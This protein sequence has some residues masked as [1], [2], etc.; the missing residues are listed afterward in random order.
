M[1]GAVRVRVWLVVAA[2]LFVNRAFSQGAQ[3]INMPKSSFVELITSSFL[4]YYTTGG[5]QEKLYM[6]T[7]KPYYSAG[8]TIY[9]SAFLVNAL[10][11][12]QTTET[13]FIYVE[14]IDATGSVVSRLK[15][16]GEGGRFNNALEIPTKQTP[17]RYTL[18]AYS[19]WQTNFGAEL[20]FS[21]R[22]NIGNYID[23]TVRTKIDYHFDGSGR[24]VASVEV[25]NNIYQPVPN[26]N[27]E[28]SLRV[29]GRTTQHLTKTDKEGIF[30]FSFRP[31]ANATDCVRLN[32]S[33]NGRKLDRTIQLPTFNDNFS[34]RFMPEGGNLVADIE[35]RVAFKAV[36]VDGYSV[37]IKGEVR[38]DDGVLVCRFESSHNGMGYFTIK[39]EKGRTYSATATMQGDVTKEFKLPVPIESGCVINLVNDG[40]KS[41]VRVAVTPDLSVGRFVAVVQSRGM[42]DYVVE[43]LR[44]PFAIPMEG[45]R[46]GVAMISIV[47]RVSMK[48]VAERLFF[49]DGKYATATINPSV[50]RFAPR[51][52]VSIDFHILNSKRQAVK[53]D[54]VVRVTDDE[55]IH[56]DKNQDNIFSYMLL[57]SDLK[58]HIENPCYYFEKRDNQRTAQLDLVMMTHGWRRYKVENIIA[59]KRPAI[60][61]LFEKE[62]SITGL[63]RGVIGNAKRP[64]VMIFRNRKE[65]LGVHPLNKSNKFE[66]TGVDSPDTTTYLL[67]A[68]NRQGS[69]SRVRIKVDPQVYPLSPT[70]AREVFQKRTFSSVPEEFLMSSKQTYYEEGG[71]PIIDIDAVVITAQRTYTYDY[72]SAL[73]DF[74]TVSG[75]MT[76]FSS[77]FDALQRFRQLEIF[78]TEVRVRQRGGF[79][80]ESVESSSQGA[81]E[82]GEGDEFIGGVEIDM[83]DNEDRMPA[84]YVNGQQMDMGALDAYPMEEVLSVSY[85]DKNESQSAGLG[86]EWGAIVMQVKN[87]NSYQKLLINSMAEVIVP[88]YCAPVEFYSPDYNVKN[89]K[90]KRDNRT[91][92]A[93]VPSLRSNS[94]GD[95]SMSFWSADRASNYRVIIEGIT[96]E[97][98]LL[99]EELVLQSK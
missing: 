68:L 10:Y 77:V 55:L 90:D 6:V 75:D 58:G 61:H 66:I 94:L 84:V 99:H 2:M 34:M 78:G 72:S 37:A 91:T 43:N 36:G 31:T 97:G 39:A 47:D 54:F 7:D 50:N 73:N 71:V 95:A 18:R 63:V 16:L 12:N 49:V 93:W 29:N 35:Q 86:S 4:N 23:D 24:V 1:K 67:Q 74:N 56:K 52:N 62:Q 85:L 17:G 25:T 14:L 88:G 21:K 45:L 89:D 48:V 64:S 28:Y 3:Q 20:L 11:F 41:V 57:N 83:G 44:Q 51:Q 32:I 81:G 60:Q 13:R 8:D 22:I 69:S 80:S 33:A 19:R 79:R 65:Y 76:R 15:V 98:E 53:G 27:V 92:I 42:V 5:I 30:R 59:Q 87:V 26:N 40:E 70:I 82:D 38:R 9:F 96:T 46:S